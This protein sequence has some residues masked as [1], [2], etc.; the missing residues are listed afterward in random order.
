MIRHLDTA[1][2]AVY[3]LRLTCRLRDSVA[4]QVF[5]HRFAQAAEAI[6]EVQLWVALPR[7]DTR[8]HVEKLLVDLLTTLLT[9]HYDQLPRP[10]YKELVQQGSR[11]HSV[12]VSLAKALLSLLPLT[13]LLLAHWYGIPLSEQFYYAAGPFA[14]ACALTVLDPRA[15]DHL[16]VMKNIGGLLTLKS[17]K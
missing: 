9:E 13:L 14:V 4:Q 16:D 12:L 1:A 15:K 6:R 3:R 17:E 5:S 10:R 8:I 11:R 2:A 7:V